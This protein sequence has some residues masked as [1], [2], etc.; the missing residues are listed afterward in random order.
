MGLVSKLRNCGVCWWGSETQKLHLSNEVIRLIGHRI[1][2]E[3]GVS[4]VRPNA[5]TLSFQFLYGGQFTLS[6]QL[7][8]AIVLLEYL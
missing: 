2:M 4:S 3:T 1:A 5:Q 7:I 6:A 8:T